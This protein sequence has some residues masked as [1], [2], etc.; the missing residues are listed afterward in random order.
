MAYYVPPVWNSGGTRPRVPHQIVPMV[1]YA[2]QLFFEVIVIQIY[3]WQYIV[4]ITVP[5][6]QW[7]KWWKIS[8]VMLSTAVQLKLFVSGR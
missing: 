6:C 3:F 2:V 7:L 1:Q 5:N 8:F 4:S